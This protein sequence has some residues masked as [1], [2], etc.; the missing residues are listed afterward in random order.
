MKRTVIMLFAATAMASLAAFGAD[1]KCCEAGEAAGLDRASIGRKLKNVVALRYG[2]DVRGEI[3]ADADRAFSTHFDD[4]RNRKANDP[5]MKPEMGAWQG[6]FWGKYMLAGAEVAEHVGDEELETWLRE[7]AV[8]FVRRYQQGDGYL[9]SYADREFLGGPGD[10]RCRFAWNIWGRKYTMWAL[11]EIGRIANAPELVEAARRMADQLIAQLDRRGLS[12]RETGYFAGLPSCSMLIPMVRLYKATGDRR[13]LEYAGKIVRDWDREDGAKPNLIRNAIG[14]KP[15]HEWYPDD[16]EWAK[17]YEMMS[18]LEGV[19]EYAQVVGG[20]EGKRL[21]E[22]VVRI[23]DKLARHE[24]NDKLGSVGDGDKF[25]GLGNGGKKGTELCD[26][27]HW[28]RLNAALYRATGDAK[29][30]E[31]VRKAYNGAFLAGILD[32]GRWCMQFVKPDGSGKPADLQVNM[33]RHHCCVDNMPRGFVVAE[34][35]ADAV[36][37]ASDVARRD[38]SITVPVWNEPG[39]EKLGGRERMLEE[40]RKLGASRVNLCL[41]KYVSDGAKRADVMRA[42]K[43]NSDWFKAHGL[44]T[45]AWIWAFWGDDEMLRKFHRITKKNGAPSSFLCPLDEGFSKIAADYVADMARTGVDMIL[46][47]DDFAYRNDATGPKV[48]C[49]CEKHLAAYR[50]ELGEDIS[51]DEFSRRVMTGGRNRW[52]DVWMKVNGEA[53]L[54]FAKEM[55][56]AADSVNPKLRLGLCSV[57]SAWDNDGTDAPAGEV[58]FF[59]CTGRKDGDRVV[60][61]EIPPFAFAG[62]RILNK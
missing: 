55:R 31:F 22:A 43:E 33:K 46:Y 9:C 18:C 61:D 47:D 7:K 2:M 53:L 45:C 4:D 19:L 56:A 30:P 21:C 32:G 12:L 37:Q 59:N 29:A 57:M 20:D 52:R 54:A 6:E 17:A 24:Y 25:R 11:L 16:N 49:L 36:A 51:A 42:L 23:R 41:D 48:S 44:S 15:V 35:M 5:W 1:W 38:Y 40:L 27:V 3:L 62:I 10:P 60:I 28:M 8:D 14:D 34:S 50:R 39:L 26:V 58:E 13:Y